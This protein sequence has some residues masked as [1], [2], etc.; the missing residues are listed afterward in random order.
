MIWSFRPYRSFLVLDK[1]ELNCSVYLQ[2]CAVNPDTCTLITKSKSHAKQKRSIHV[3]RSQTVIDTSLCSGRTLSDWL[4]Q[5]KTCQLRRDNNMNMMKI[6][7]YLKPLRNLKNSWKIKTA[8]YY[9][10][11]VILGGFISGW[12][13]IYCTCHEWYSTRRT[14]SLNISPYIPHC[15]PILYKCWL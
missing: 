5:N 8:S 4:T 12:M 10:I 13:R 11:I 15:H 6:I 1:F 14:G 3:E 2:N 7:C 9:I